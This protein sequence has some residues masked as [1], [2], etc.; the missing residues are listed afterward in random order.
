[1]R[2]PY[3]GENVKILVEWETGRHISQRWKEI[4]RF[5]THAFDT[6]KVHGLVK[7]TDQEKG[8]WG[9]LDANQL[10]SATCASKGG[11]S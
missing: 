3:R 6:T 8:E 5:G 4:A 11:L 7:V 2:S 9:S 1:M 10:M